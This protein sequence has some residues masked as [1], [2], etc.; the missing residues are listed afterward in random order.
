MSTIAELARVV[1]SKNAG[2]LY[3]TLD[4]MFADEQTYLKV[5]DSGVITPARVAE[6][7]R[8]SANAVQVIPYDVAYAIKITIPRDV[9]SGDPADNDVYGA[10]QHAPLLSIEIPD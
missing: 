7:Y 8:L 1:R 3:F 10:Q 6:L 2:A 9:P 5:R 4:L